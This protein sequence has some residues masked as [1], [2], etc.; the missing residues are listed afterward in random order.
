MRLLIPIMLAVLT[1]SSQTFA[2]KAD[3]APPRW[4]ISPRT[5]PASQG[6]PRNPPPRF[7]IPARGTNG[8]PLP[9]IGLP[10]PPVGLQ[11][12]PGTGEDG[13][14][15]NHRRGTFPV[16]PV[17]IYYAPFYD[18]F[19]PYA[20]PA[21]APAPVEQPPQ[22]GRLI[23][24][25]QPEG[26]QVFIDGY[27]T[28]VPEDFD[29]AHG[30]GAVEAGQ[31]R[32]DLSA[33]GYEPL[34]VDVRIA[35]TQTITYRETLKRTQAPALLPNGPTTF[36]LIPGCYMGNVPPKDAHLPA[37]CDLGRAVEFKY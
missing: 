19:V 36:Y 1:M 18:P 10:L 32:I 29:L 20:E 8:L 12:P 33:P 31:H 26:A 17:A 37:T 15:R 3:Q 7:T 23:L 27:Y 34:A 11:P 28:G 4:T 22:T 14:G 5:G 30:G 24:A 16:W 35:P 13:H 2:Q 6:W 9:E 21:P 25:P